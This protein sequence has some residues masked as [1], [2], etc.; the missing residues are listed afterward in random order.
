MALLELLRKHQGEPEADALRE[1]LRWLAQQLMELEVS[2]LVGAQRYERTET[3]KTYRNGYRSRPWDTR[4]GT[5]ELRIP[6]LRQGSYFPS[7]LEP[8]RRAERALVAVVQEAYVQGVSTRKVDDL[9]RALGLDGISKSE[10]S[11]LCAELD[12]R[13]ERFRN[14]PLEGEYPYVWL[15]AKPI[16]VRQDHRVV[17]MAAVIA[18]GVKRTGERE[19]LGFDVG[20]AETYE[21]WLAFL[22]SLVARGLKGVRLVISDA[23]EGLKR[24]ISEVLAGASWQR[25]RVHFMRNL[26]ARVPKHAQPMVAALVR[27]IFAQPDLESAREQLEHV[28]ANLDRRFPQAAALLRDAMEDVLA[29]MAFPTEHWRRIHS[30]N[31]LER[32]NRELARRCDVVGIF[33]NMAAAIRLLGALLEEQQDE[34]LVSRRYFSLESMAKIDA[35]TSH[36]ATRLHETEATLKVLAM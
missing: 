20:A 36:E 3:R 31:V 33:P 21:F 22:R 29:Y 16:K 35:C 7:L 15:D 24:A 5:I 14:R 4:V 8:R 10:V 23:H 11:R 26:L 27:T 19:V 9:V 30:T 6:K 13:M 32:L 34:W 28:A 1:G 2:E 17:N 12:E 25:C 18:V